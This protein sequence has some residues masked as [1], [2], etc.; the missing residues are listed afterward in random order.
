[1]VIS[2]ST[3]VMVIHAGASSPVEIEFIKKFIR[4]NRPP[5]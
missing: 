5:F 4:Q 2:T 1:M 3:M